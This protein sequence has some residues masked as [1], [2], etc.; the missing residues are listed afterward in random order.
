MENTINNTTI[1]FNDNKDNIIMEAILINENEVP[2]I[3][4]TI[5]G[6][7]FFSLQFFKADGTPREAQ[8]Q[9]HVANPRNEKITPNGKGE[10]AHKAL[11]G[12]RIK[13]YETHNKMERTGVYRQCR[14]DRLISLKVKGTTYLVLH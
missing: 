4:E 8:A 1:T 12:G 11:E 7:E 2:R 13:F 14:I 9:L 10:S 5:K 3:L 6:A